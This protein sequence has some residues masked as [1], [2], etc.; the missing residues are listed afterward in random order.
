MPVILYLFHFVSLVIPTSVGRNLIA[1]LAL[2]S[3]GKS[4]DFSM[5]QVMFSNNLEHNLPFKVVRLSFKKQDHSVTKRCQYLWIIY[6]WIYFTFL[7]D[8]A[9]IYHIDPGINLNWIR[10]KS[11]NFTV[12]IPPKS[13]SCHCV[14]WYLL[15]SDLHNIFYKE[16]GSSKVW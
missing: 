1:P 14:E 11:W 7:K 15:S 5:I 13:K 8:N 12:K 9:V 4:S 16:N 3:I 2:E 6:S 10:W